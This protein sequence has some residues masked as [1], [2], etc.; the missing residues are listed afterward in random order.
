MKE[1]ERFIYAVWASWGG[2]EAKEITGMRNIK[3]E[4]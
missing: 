3:N 4:S 1:A 2:W